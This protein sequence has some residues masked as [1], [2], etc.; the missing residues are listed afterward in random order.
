VLYVKYE[1]IQTDISFIIKMPE[2]RRG[3]DRI[4]PLLL[5]AL[6]PSLSQ[7]W[8]SRFE[9]TYEISWQCLKP[10]SFGSGSKYKGEYTISR[11]KLR[12]GQGK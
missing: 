9:G 10:I 8:E 2:H 5:P 12:S 3:Q 11:N 6:L 1:E 7:V 4:Q